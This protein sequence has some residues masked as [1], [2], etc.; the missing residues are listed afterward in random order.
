MNES[1]ID[2]R[3]HFIKE[4][5]SQSVQLHSQTSFTCLPPDGDPK[6]TLF[7]LKNGEIITPNNDDGSTQ[8]KN[9][10]DDN[11]S[12]L[13]EEERED[14]DESDL[15]PVNLSPHHDHSNYLI[16][17]DGSLIIKQAS[18]LDQANY[19]CAVKN[20]AGIR[21]S[22]PAT[23]IVYGKR[24]YQFWMDL[25]QPHDSFIQKDKKIK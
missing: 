24:Y 21:Y 9:D 10:S 5:I 7:W 11:E 8:P 18:L 19:T 12:D 25:C 20:P 17:H 1:S 15:I 2:L 6:P 22:E 3:K 23:L 13:S 4:P 14:D 16:T